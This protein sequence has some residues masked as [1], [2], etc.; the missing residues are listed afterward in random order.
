[1]TR[2]PGYL[3]SFLSIA[4]V[5]LGSAAVYGLGR[6]ATLFIQDGPARRRA[7]SRL[8]GRVLR[9]M[10]TLL[11]ATFIKLGQ[12]MSTRPDLFSAELIDELRLL[13]DQ[14][15]PFAFRH[16]RAAILR[17]FQRPI[18]EVFS[19]FDRIPVAA[20]SIAQVHHARLK[21]GTEVAVKVVRPRIRKKIARDAFILEC[22]ARLTLLNAKFRHAQPVEHLEEFIDGILAQTDLHIEAKNYV[23]FRQNFEGFAGVHFPE[24][25]GNASGASV[26]TME[27]L[28]G[29][30]IDDTTAETFP[31]VAGTMRRMFLKMCFEDGFLHADLHPG[32]MLITPTGGLCVFDVGLVKHLDDTVLLTFI[33]FAKC[34]TLGNTQDF[35][36][37]LKRFHGYMHDV[38]WAAVERD[39]EALSVQF[40][41]Q[42][43]ADLQWGSFIN[44]LFIASRRHGVRPIPE[45]ALVMVG[46][47]T[48]EGIGK[49]LSPG[50]NSFDEMARFLMPIIAKKGLKIA[51]S[52]P[53]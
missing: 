36:A 4:L 37:H 52:T 15:P 29:Q 43:N 48:A 31:D 27:F 32:N 7:V 49:M 23:R 30:R 24:V 14:L 50:A 3:M 44:E 9:A 51:P 22:L 25:Y 45:L 41:D 12:V 35:V 2:W 28:H 34:V 5:G 53:A 42:T 33:D 21:D 46:V 18:G 47:I 16:V 8:K 13:Q 26:L 40:R 11:G 1:M 10:M 17:D 38:N 39:A 19:E 6:V 20:A